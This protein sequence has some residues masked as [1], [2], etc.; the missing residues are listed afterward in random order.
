MCWHCKG[1]EEGAV[2]AALAGEWVLGES[3]S[4]DAPRRQRRA[5]GAFCKGP[6]GPGTS[7]DIPGSS[8]QAGDTG[9]GRQQGRCLC[10]NPAAALKR[11]SRKESMCAWGGG[12]RRQP[13]V[14][15][16]TLRNWHL[17]LQRPGR[18]SRVTTQPALPPC[19]TAGICLPARAAQGAG[20]QPLILTRCAVR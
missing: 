9:R 3:V 8:S 14:I 5:Q 17:T 10:T 15:L 19:S 11:Q 12:L 6:P 2:N 16:E 1:S 13:G 4:R 18:Q 20:S 7:L